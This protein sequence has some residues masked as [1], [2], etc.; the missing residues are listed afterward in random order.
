MDAVEKLAILSADKAKRHAYQR[1]LDELHSY[2]NI[3]EENEKYRA[4]LSDKDVAFADKDAALAVNAAA[5]A[6]K[7]ALIARLIAQLES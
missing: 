6:E 3:V 5:L 7:D 1:R 4:L 2:N